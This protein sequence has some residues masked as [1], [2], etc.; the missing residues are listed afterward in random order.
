MAKFGE[1]D[2]RWLVEKVRD[3]RAHT[4]SNSSSRLCHQQKQQQLVAQLSQPGNIK[5]ILMVSATLE[6]LLGSGRTHVG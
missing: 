4:C 6:R 1:G 2:P 3:G 5:G